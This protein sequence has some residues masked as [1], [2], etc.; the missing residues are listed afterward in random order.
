M[1]DDS[2]TAGAAAE[3]TS[4]LPDELQGAHENRYDALKWKLILVAALGA[5]GLGLQENQHPIRLLLALIPFVCIYVDLICTTLNV[6]IIVIGTYY[7]NLRGDRYERFAQHNRAVFQMEDWALN[8]ST[9]LICW[10]ITSI[11][12]I[13]L[14]RFLSD[15]ANVQLLWNWLFWLAVLVLAMGLFL[16]GTLLADGEKP[17]RDAAV[18]FFG[19]LLVGEAVLLHWLPGTIIWQWPFWEPVLLTLAGTTG[20]MAANYTLA[21]SQRLITELSFPPD[22]LGRQNPQLA[23]LV[24]P[25][26]TPAQLAAV[27][28]LLTQKG[29]FIFQSLPNGLFP[30]AAG[31]D[32]KAASGYQNVWVRDNIYVARAHYLCGD[33]VTAKRTLAALMEHFQRS[34]SRFQAI[35]ANPALARDPMNRPHIRFAG[36]NLAE[37]KAPWHHAQNDA[38]GYFL[39]CYC[40]MAQAGDLPC[41]APELECLAEFPRYFQAI[42]YWRDEDSGHWEEDRKVSASS[43][44]AV[45]AGLREF[46]CLLESLLKKHPPGSKPPLTGHPVTPATLQHLQKHGRDALAEILPCETLAPAGLFRRYDSA[47]LFLIYPLRVVKWPYARV[48]LEDVETH[49]QGE[50]GIRRYLGDSYWHPDYRA[51]MQSEKRAANYGSNR[52]ER[53]AGARIRGEAQWCIFD[54]II[55]VIYG[56]RYLELRQ[57]DEKA[58]AAEMLRLQTVYFNRALNQLTGKSRAYGEFLCPEAYCLENGNYVP[59]DQTPLLWTQANLWLALHQMQISLAASGRPKPS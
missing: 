1:G 31:L 6:R 4:K 22:E 43:I 19:V 59:N 5:A 7:A 23:A 44:G 30:A 58:E 50:Y 16:V 39:W 24:Q 2:S 47:L 10:L 9:K 51:K 55:S 17:D 14:L 40:K 27:R 13:L 8:G 57:T 45:V 49:L 21:T 28:G 37:I 18:F 48:I 53:D 46:E 52:T 34:R 41:E 12:L 35:I 25:S 26:Y 38:L 11:G 36:E 15:P 42:E 32:Q 3:R 54:P 20:Y 29:V 56:E 33:P